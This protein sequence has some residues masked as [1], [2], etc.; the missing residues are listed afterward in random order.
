MAPSPKASPKGGSPAASPKA[1]PAAPAAKRVTFVDLFCGAGGWTAGLRRAGLHHLT[2]VELDAWAAKS[3]AANHG[4]VTHARVQDALAAPGFPKRADVVVASPPCQ[5]FSMAGSRAV[6]SDSDELYRAALAV[7]T[8][9]RAR[10]FVMENVVGL[11]SKKTA[12]GQLVWDRVRRDLHAAGFP[13]V[14]HAVLD[15][16]R[17]EVPQTRRRVVVVASRR[18]WRAAAP[19]FPPPEVPGFD[20]RAAR[21][22]LPAARVP[23]AHWTTPAKERYF[24]QRRVASKGAYVRYVDPEQPAKTARASYFK[25]AGAEALVRQTPPPGSAAST[26]TRRLTP[27]EFARIQS[28]PDAYRF[29]GP[30]TQV[31]KQIGNAVPPNLA[32]H[33][34]AWLLA[35]LR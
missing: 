34:G 7:A 22:L 33:V 31:Y 6:G 15:A 23:A 20:A 27:L 24:E 19:A 26:T 25:S 35:A 17:Y 10:A 8:K 5:S 14:Q 13:H 29:E 21:V 11:L 3:Y 28:F 4:A 32:F 12:D 18:P 1:A 2:G 30:P 16:S 9:V